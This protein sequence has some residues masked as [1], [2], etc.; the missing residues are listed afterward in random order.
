MIRNYNFQV[1]IVKK[2]SIFAKFSQFLAIFGLIFLL[3]DLILESRDTCLANLSLVS[4]ETV[5]DSATLVIGSA[6]LEK[7]GSE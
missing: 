1:E 3:R 5:R 7:T 6:I 4:R 2:W